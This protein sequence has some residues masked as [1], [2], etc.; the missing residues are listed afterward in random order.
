M[1]VDSLIITINYEEYIAEEV[2]NDT[3][4]DK[5]NTESSNSTSEDNLTK[6]EEEPVTETKE[7]I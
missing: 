3:I 5:N 1:T 4:E 2:V 7:D 6:T